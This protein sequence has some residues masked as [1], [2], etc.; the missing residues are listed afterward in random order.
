M[1]GAAA[2]GMDWSCGPTGRV[3]HRP[4]HRPLCFGSTWGR[5]SVPAGGNGNRH[6]DSRVR[7]VVFGQAIL[8]SVDHND[9]FP[10]CRTD[11]LQTI[12]SGSE[13]RSD[14]SGQYCDGGLGNA[15]CRRVQPWND[16]RRHAL[17]PHAFCGAVCAARNNCTDSLLRRWIGHRF[18]SGKLGV[19]PHVGHH[20]YGQRRVITAHQFGLACNCTAG[21]LVCRESLRGRSGHSHR[22]GHAAG[23]TWSC[24]D[25]AGGGVRR[26]RWIGPPALLRG[27]SAHG[28][29][30]RGT[31]ACSAR[32]W[33]P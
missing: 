11:R 20:V 15:D 17:V 32:R 13:G 33:R 2:D 5:P 29:R 18:L 23:Y 25:S 27:P 30:P 26:H 9:R 31:H 6:G 19:A 28:R 1:A 14:C 24:C 7:R 12:S 10:T 22:R 3:Q 16:F 4:G 8:A 21:C